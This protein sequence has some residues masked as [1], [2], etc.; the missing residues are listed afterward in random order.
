[1]PLSEA[2][3]C[4]DWLLIKHPWIPLL[5]PDFLTLGHSPRLPPV[6][7]SANWERKRNTIFMFPLWIQQKT[8]NIQN[9]PSLFPDPPE[10]VSEIL[11]NATPIPLPN[12]NT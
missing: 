6:A 4:S 8:P 12:P 9:I 2:I 5:S 10:I 11:L 7:S 1:M 3:L